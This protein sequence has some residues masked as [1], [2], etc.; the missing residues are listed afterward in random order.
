MNYQYDLSTEERNL[1]SGCVGKELSAF[2]LTDD[3][4][5][6][7]F[8]MFVLRFKDADVEVRTKEI[9]HVSP[10]FEETNTVE[11]VHRPDRNSSSPL[12]EELANG[13]L[14]PIPLKEVSVGK[15]VRGISVAVNTMSWSDEDT[16]SGSY[17]RGIVLHFDDEDVV[18]DK[19]ALNWEYF[20]HATRCPAATY[21]FKV[22][23]DPETPEVMTTVRAEKIA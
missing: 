20:W 18:F 9:V 1:L 10:W 8:E 12:A 7:S 19:G 22:E 4:N 15:I 21:E 23:D 14:K 2:L 3:D 16:G 6:Q 5:A 13:K 17:V 11:V